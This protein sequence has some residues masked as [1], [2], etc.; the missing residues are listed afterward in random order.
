MFPQQVDTTKI[1]VSL[2]IV[3]GKSGI[4][5]SPSE[6]EEVIQLEGATKS[7]E[8]VYK[9]VAELCLDISDVS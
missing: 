9:R 2:I 6:Q 5:S 8:N 4:P 1:F 7:Y 3:E